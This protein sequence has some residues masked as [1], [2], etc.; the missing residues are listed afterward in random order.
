MEEN[1]PSVESRIT[2]WWIVLAALVFVA[3]SAG[4]I[5]FAI[6][7]NDGQTDSAEVHNGISIDVVTRIAEWKGNKKGA[8]TLSFDDS[9]ISQADVAVPAMLEREL[10]GTWFINPGKEYYLQRQQV[11]EQILPAAGHELANHT[12]HHEGAKDLVE[13]EYEIGESAR[14]I[15]SL[16]PAGASNLDSSPF[17]RD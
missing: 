5:L 8:F 16:R 1:A 10:V 2:R 6:L 9:M 14:I 15:W 4:I 12:M 3:G 17:P 7:T 11:W 13:A